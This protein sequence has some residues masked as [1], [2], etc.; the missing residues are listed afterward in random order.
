MSRSIV[1]VLRELSDACYELADMW[2]GNNAEGVDLNDFNLDDDYEYPFDKDFNE[3]ANDV[4]N[5]VDYIDDVIGSHT[6]K[7]NGKVDMSHLHLFDS[8][9]ESK[10][11]NETWDGE[12]EIADLVDRA[13]SW[14]DDGEDLDDAVA[15]ALDDGL[16]YTHTVRVLADHYDVIPD[17]S[18]LINLFY[19]ELY[20]D[21]YNE[22]A[23]YYEEVHE[24]NEEEIEE[25]YKRIKSLVERR[26]SKFVYDEDD[27][28]AE[29]LEI[30]EK[31]NEKN[32][33]EG[34]AEIPYR[35]IVVKYPNFAKWFEKYYEGME[36]N[37]EGNLDENS[38][39]IDEYWEFMETPDFKALL[40]FISEKGKQTAS[41][42]YLE[43]GDV[44]DPGEGQDETEVA[45]EPM[46]RYVR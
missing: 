3:V 38:T 40:K 26:G 32:D 41:K 36:S 19:E 8:L 1:T 18:E 12:D 30:K 21:V 33:F 13:K 39:P 4:A 37:D 46:W 7:T 35:N 25:D 31:F 45:L 14:I 10:K 34:L 29:L 20:G 27:L 24:D 6:F 2:E 42:Y 15:R 17:D 9:K 28:N 16:I 11:L 43:I 23:D 5:W 44:Y 22:V